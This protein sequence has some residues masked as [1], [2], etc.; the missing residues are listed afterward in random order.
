[1]MMRHMISNLPNDGTLETACL[2]QSDCRYSDCE[3][4]CA[5]DDLPFHPFTSN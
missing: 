4:R 2:D 5:N 3:N 1:M